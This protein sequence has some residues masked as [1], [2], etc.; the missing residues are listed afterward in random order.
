[1]SFKFSTIKELPAKFE[2]D[3]QVETDVDQEGKEAYQKIQANSDDFILSRKLLDQ[4]KYIFD[5]YE[6]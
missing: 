4:M 3:N 2:K 5:M 6:R 1:M